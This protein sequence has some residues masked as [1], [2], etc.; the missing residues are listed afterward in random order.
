VRRVDEQERVF[1]R[2]F[3]RTSTIRRHKGE[4]HA[5]LRHPQARPYD[6]VIYKD[7]DPI[8][9]RERRTP[10]ISACTTTTPTTSSTAGSLAD[11]TDRG[12][13]AVVRP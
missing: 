3:H 13:V 12:G 2:S 11:G 10:G 8:A 9:G 5:R 7:L 6:V 4:H 1:Y